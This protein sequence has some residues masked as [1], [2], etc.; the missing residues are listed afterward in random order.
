MPA[1]G[2]GLGAD[3][4]RGVEQLVDDRK[5]AASHVGVPGDTCVAPRC[6]KRVWWKCIDFV[7]GSPPL[8]SRLRRPLRSS[9][10]WATD[11][12]K[13]RRFGIWKAP[14]LG[15]RLRGND[16]CARVC[17]RGND[18]CARACLRGNDGL[19]K[20]LPSRERRL[21]EGLSSRERR[22]CEGL[23]SRGNDAL[24]AA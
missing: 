3:Q 18:G 13:M 6:G 17:L 5:S 2:H 14:P 12:V 9:P 24:A 23:S 16:G 19:C 1:L 4:V 11:M 7:F 15:S 20:G 8:G 10:R 21:C 22:L